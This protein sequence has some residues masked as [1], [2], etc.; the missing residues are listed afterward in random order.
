MPQS[1]LTI[2]VRNG[3]LHLWSDGKLTDVLYQCLTKWVGWRYLHVDAAILKEGDVDLP[4]G[5]T[6]HFVPPFEYRQLDWICAQDPEW[7]RANHVNYRDNK[8]IGLVDTLAGVS[9][10]GDLTTLP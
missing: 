9:E 6:D 1:G 2:A 7:M 10:S 3:N 8:W 4:E 5:F